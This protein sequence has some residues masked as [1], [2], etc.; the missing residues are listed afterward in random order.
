VNNWLPVI[1]TLSGAIVAGVISLL[2]HWISNRHAMQ[3]TKLVLAEERAR[4][5]IE[6]RLER[7]QAFYGT[8]EKLLDATVQFRVQQ[9]WQGI[10][11]KEPGAT[12][13][14]WVPSYDTARGDF[15]DQLSNV[16]RELLL[17]DEAIQ[18][19]YDREDISWVRWISV[20]IDTDNGVTALVD[21]EDAIRRFRLWVAKRYRTQFEERLKGADHAT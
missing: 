9:V 6:R 1:A 5:A 19:E 15:E 3:H 12:I 14:E 10:A 2:V 4:W 8:I 13:P 7:L 20:A 18:S 16:S 17:L 11:Q 21:L